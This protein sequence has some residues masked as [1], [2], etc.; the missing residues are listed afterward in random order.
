MSF[1][2]NLDNGFTL[3]A[4][5]NFNFEPP[6]LSGFIPLNASLP[7]S[8]ECFLDF[9]AMAAARVPLPSNAGFGMFGDKRATSADLRK[10]ARETGQGGLY[11][12]VIQ[13]YE[14]CESMQEQETA[15]TYLKRFIDSGI[16]LFG[17]AIL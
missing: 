1:R 16:W 8:M 17:G 12:M 7:P 6:D 13:Y 3:G 4:D 2:L 9:Y 10:F 14:R 11:S 15:E 5:H